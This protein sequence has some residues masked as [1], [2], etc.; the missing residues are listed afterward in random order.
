LSVFGR[1]ALIG[2]L[3]VGLGVTV[4]WMLLDDSERVGVILA[5]LIAYPVQIFAFWLLLR[6]R[7]EPTQFVFY[8]GIGIMLR[9]LTVVTVG[10]V[11]WKFELVDPAALLLT[12]VGFFFVLLLMEPAFLKVES[13]N[14]R[15]TI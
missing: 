9:V 8:W 12:L 3:V 11:S 14:P 6:V 13:N 1:Y 2:I 5:A 15:K 4:L 7:G 10:L